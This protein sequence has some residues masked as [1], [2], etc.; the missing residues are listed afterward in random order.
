[1]FINDT[2][3]ADYTAT[4]TIPQIGTHGTRAGVQGITTIGNANSTSVTLSAAGYQFSGGQTTIT[5]AGDIVTAAD[6]NITSDDNIK[7]D[8]GTGSLKFT[9]DFDLVSTANKTVEIA[10]NSLAVDSGG[11]S[12]DTLT[13]TSGAGNGATNGTI[14][15]GGTI[16]SAQLKTVT[17]TAATAINLGG[18]ITLGNI[19][20]GGVTVTGPAVL[21]A[22][23]DVDAS[24]NNGT[25]SFSSTINN[26]DSGTAR[27][28]QLDTG[29]GSITVSGIIGDVGNSGTAIG[30]IDINKTAGTGAITLAGIGS[31]SAAGN[32][33]TV[34]IGNTTTCLLYTSPSPR[35]EL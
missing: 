9:G 27:N 34:D 7:L 13:V 2:A 19:A 33:G 28:L 16:G 21:T 4:L 26:D 12:V 24:A 32:A 10:G 25:I 14:T 3:G 11:N 6:A 30:T 20:G 1:M 18:N 17:L 31:S 29:A 5:A 23:V 35:D 22:A 8:P 15:I